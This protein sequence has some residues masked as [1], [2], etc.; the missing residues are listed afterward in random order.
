L[1]E[2]KAVIDYDLKIKEKE[3]DTEFW[4]FIGNPLYRLFER[5]IAEKCRNSSEQ[6]QRSAQPVGLGKIFYC[7]LLTAEI[8]ECKVLY[9]K[10]KV[11]I[12]QCIVYFT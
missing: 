4:K 9:T 12:T 8:V 7:L 10:S 11:Y 2:L 3:S 6:R 1:H 5:S